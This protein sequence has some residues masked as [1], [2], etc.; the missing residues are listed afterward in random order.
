MKKATL[1]ALT[2]T[3]LL[4]SPTTLANEEEK[5]EDVSP[6]FGD[7]IITI[8]HPKKPDLNS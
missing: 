7:I 1:A 2:L 8:I 4:S 5:I 6:T 3:A